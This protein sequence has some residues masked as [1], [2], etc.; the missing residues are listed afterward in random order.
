M[1]EILTNFN[2]LLSPYWSRQHGAYITLIS[3]W[4]ITCI[5]TG[6]SELQLV[7]VAFLLSGLN[8]VELLSEKFYR[9]SIMP[10]RKIFWLSAYLFITV[11][12]GIRLFLFSLEFLFLL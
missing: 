1:P 5:I 7:A 8:L 9:K 11:V 12:T 3:A 4:F 10:A 6:F 2:K